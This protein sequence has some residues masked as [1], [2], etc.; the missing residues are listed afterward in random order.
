MV[1]EG[2]GAG[3]PTVIAWDTCTLRGVLAAGAG[4]RML[5][6]T[7]FEASKGHT[8]WL[9]PELD[10]MISGLG[11]SPGDVDAV[12]AGIGPGTFTGVKVGV[13]CAKAVSMGLGVPVVGVSTLDILAEGSDGD[14]DMVLASID[15][16]RGQLYAAAYARGA[17]G[18]ERLTD[19][20]CAE[21]RVIAG[22][23]A[24]LPFKR[25]ALIGEVPPDLESELV[26]RGRVFPS[27]DE[28]PSGAA[29]L[30]LADSRLSG[31]GATDPVAL[32]P[33]Y[34]KKPT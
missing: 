9:M 24:R 8:T 4:G 3:G 22:A 30:A 27:R 13:A 19:Y 21:P 2:S 25:L 11:L 12:A 32:S 17:G 18:L 1:P 23:L 10:R 33:I 15:A 5:E 34:L 29:L 20:M 16:R 26:R 31:G 14:A 6:E 28:Y 7:F